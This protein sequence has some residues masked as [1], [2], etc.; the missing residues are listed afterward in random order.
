MDSSNTHHN[1]VSASAP[2]P[3]CHPLETDIASP[4]RF[5]C[6]FHYVP[7]PL[8]R[9]AAD[10]VC[11]YLSTRNEWSEE[12]AKGKML[13][14]LIVESHD[15]RRWFLA[16]Y[17]GLL[18][19]RNDHPYFVPPVFDAMQPNG[20]FKVHEAEITA[21]N[22]LIDSLQQSPDY[23]NAK[24]DSESISRQGQQEIEDYRKQM[25]AA[26]ARR[27]SLRTSLSVN[28]VK[29][30]EEMVRESQFM[31][32][33]LRRMKARI[34]D[35]QSEA[36]ALTRTFADRIEQLR[37][38]RAMLSDNLQNWLFEQY[39]ML[40]ANGMK[41]NLLSIFAD[42]PQRIPPAGAGDCC[43]PKL[44]QYAYLH[45]LHPVCMAEFWWGQSP[46]REIRQ[47][48]TFYPAC[49][50][51]CLP[52]LTHMLQGLDVDPYE[53][54]HG[55][56]QP[57]TV[58]YEDSDLIVV[59]KPSGLKSVPGRSDYPS[60]LSI[61]AAQHP[62]HKSLRLAHRLDMDTS[63]LLIIA[64][65]KQTYL[66]LQR[67]FAA[68]TVKKRYV[69]LLSGVFNGV[70]S[71]IISLPLIADPLDRPYQKV[72][73]ENGKEAITEYQTMGIQDGHSRVCLFPKTGRTHQLRIH[74]AHSQ[75]LAMPILG[76]RLYGTHEDWLDGTN[77]NRLYLH[78][79]AITFIHP[80]TGKEMTVERNAPF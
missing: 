46:R 50:G 13:G 5:T 9:M 67:Q 35:R 79:E 48:G 68:H 74:C 1:V 8:C 6:P 42:T 34:K 47:H 40:D 26:K 39:D 11:R 78:A 73:T 37:H 2:A 66:H 15:G 52:I 62:Q 30:R 64:K 33:E 32:A 44:L 31:K 49:R 60:V 75:G 20:Y 12:L 28:D 3:A 57:L 36:D 54:E 14:V 43:A 25:A 7:H 59:D 23:L 53:V 69:A 76:D 16:A 21:I 38:Q 72:D 77:A 63:G 70:P 4:Q 19:G 45:N 41:R 29:A 10:E 18:D 51:K 24:A 55:V 58:V 17:S 80:A 65:N 71:G 27:D 22:R 61:L 56:T